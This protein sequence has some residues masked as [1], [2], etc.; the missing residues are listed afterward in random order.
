MGQGDIFMVRLPSGRYLVRGWND[1]ERYGIAN[2]EVFGGESIMRLSWDQIGPG[3]H[4]CT[5]RAR[6]KD[7]SP[8]PAHVVYKHIDL[9]GVAS[10]VAA[11]RQTEDDGTCLL[12]ELLPGKYAIRCV[13]KDMAHE[14]YGVGDVSDS[15]KLSIEMADTSAIAVTVVNADE[16]GLDYIEA[17]TVRIWVRKK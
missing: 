14:G 3:E 8:C 2:V 12:K 4:T 9:K 15:S 11:E 17:A 13:G 10:P 7:G 1:G 6:T 16:L 5:V